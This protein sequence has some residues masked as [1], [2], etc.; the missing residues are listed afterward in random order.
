MINQTIKYKYDV[1]ALLLNKW[2]KEYY[3]TKSE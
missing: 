2:Y 3:G 1:L